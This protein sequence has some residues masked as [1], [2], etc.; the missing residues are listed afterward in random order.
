MSKYMVRDNINAVIV[1]SGV[2]ESKVSN[3][4]LEIFKEFVESAK[5]SHPS[6]K[7]EVNMYPIVTE[8]PE[9]VK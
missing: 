1:V 5:K 6:I 9:E 4:A 2:N 7:L 8:L 3:K